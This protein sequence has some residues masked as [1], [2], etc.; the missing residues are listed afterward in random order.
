MVEMIHKE[1]NIVWF[2]ELF[3]SDKCFYEHKNIYK[4]TKYGTHLEG[5]SIIDWLKNTGNLK[6]RI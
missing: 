5:R 6:L 2:Y 4:Y 1:Q 3:D